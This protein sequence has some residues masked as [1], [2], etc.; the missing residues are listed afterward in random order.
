MVAGTDYH[1][2][3]AIGNI[4]FLF[5]VFGSCAFYL[6]FVLSEAIVYGAIAT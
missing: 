2:A 1:H 3:A 6:Y 5:S 4:D